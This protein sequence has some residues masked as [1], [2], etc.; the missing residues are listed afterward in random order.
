M[1]LSKMLCV[2]NRMNI[3]VDFASNGL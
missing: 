3:K 1:S 2:K